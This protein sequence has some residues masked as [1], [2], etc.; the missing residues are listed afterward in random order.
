MTQALYAH[1]NNKTLKQNK[2]KQKNF[3]FF[4]PSIQSP[5]AV[6]DPPPPLVY[7]RKS[8]L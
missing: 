2:T 4:K 7:T 5:I 8:R 1:M 6:V 3:S